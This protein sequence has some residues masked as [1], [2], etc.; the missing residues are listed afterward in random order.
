MSCKVKKIDSMRNLFLL[1]TVVLFQLTG[2]QKLHLKRN[3]MP[4]YNIEI[5][6]SAKDYVIT[7]IEDSIE[8][9]E[10]TGASLPYGSS[11]G[12]WGSSGASFTKRS[13]TPIGADIV[14]FSRY[15]DKFYR[16]N[17]HFPVERMKELVKRAYAAHESLSSK[18]PMKEYIDISEEPDYRKKYNEYQ[19]SYS[20]MTD[21]V[22]GFAPKG[23]VVVWV[24]YAATQ[25]EVGRYQAEVIK[26]DKKYADKF[27]KSI[28]Q[29]REDIKNDLFDPNASPEQWDNYR[30]RYPYAFKVSSENKGFRL[31]EIAPYYYN[32]EYSTLLRPW[33]LD[34]SEKERA[35]P[36]SV[37]IKWETGKGRTYQGLVYFDWAKTNEAFKK[38]GTAHNVLEFKI[39]PD[40][41]VL[42]TELNGQPLPVDSAR[43]YFNPND[44]FRDSYK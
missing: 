30:T 33:A 32:A 29:T 19:M 20:P 40:D 26:D 38:Y 5:S 23:M 21:L 16:L 2:C 27:F 7:P 43:I 41:N 22:F 25:I 17:A 18:A 39:T 28:T 8:T 35:I 6:Q 10:H 1:T 42:T 9:L 37:S 34:S 31:M 13:G 15:E 11:S 24:R 44:E 4:V 14:Y 3:V 12:E 36:K